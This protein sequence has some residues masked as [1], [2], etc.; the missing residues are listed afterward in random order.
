[1]YFTW[2]LVDKTAVLKN[3]APLNAFCARV[4]QI[5]LEHDGYPQNLEQKL[6]VEFNPGISP[7]CSQLDQVATAARHMHNAC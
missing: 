7:S 1:M 4:R 3:A 2:Y 5:P 6:Q